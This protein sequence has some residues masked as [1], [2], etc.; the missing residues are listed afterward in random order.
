MLYDV[1][2]ATFE[3]LDLNGD[4]IADTKKAVA[5]TVTVE[6]ASGDEAA[7][8]AMAQGLQVVTGVN[9]ASRDAEDAP[10]ATADATE[11]VKR[12]PGRP[13]KVD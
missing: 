7:A 12:A 8:L 11:P 13:R 3:L 10:S 2:G 9:V 5:Q 6:A 4:G 1:T